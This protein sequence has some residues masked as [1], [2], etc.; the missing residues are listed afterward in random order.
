MGSSL[1]SHP[2][3]TCWEVIRL[4]MMLAAFVNKGW[5]CKLFCL[6]MCVFVYLVLSLQTGDM[7]S[8]YA[9]RCPVAAVGDLTGLHSSADVSASRLQVNTLAVGV[10]ARR[11]PLS[12]DEA[13][14][15]ILEIA[16]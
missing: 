6:P 5:C 2:R 14:H 11:A 13:S 16:G 15:D 4:E 7:A 12:S 9:R 1:S 10:W 3:F 8:G